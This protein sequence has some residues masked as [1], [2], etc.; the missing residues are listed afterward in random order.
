MVYSVHL[1]LAT[2]TF[3]TV[4][5]SDPADAWFLRK[6]FYSIGVDW[7]FNLDLLSEWF[8]Q[9]SENL[10]QGRAIPWKIFGICNKL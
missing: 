7:Y 1:S 8:W 2:V 6:V 5:D 10:L 4:N 3:V 9:L